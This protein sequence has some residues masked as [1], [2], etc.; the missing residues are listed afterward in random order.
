[1]QEYD[2]VIV[3]GGPA[4][5]TAGLY[6]SRAKLKAVL[7]EKKRLE[8]ASQHGM[9][10]GLPRLRTNKGCGAGAADGE[11]GAKAGLQIEY[12]G[13]SASSAMASISWSSWRAERKSSPKLLSSPLVAS[14]ENWAFQARMSSWDEASYCAICD[15]A[16]YQDQEIAVVGG[17]D[18]AI[19]EALPHPVRQQGPYHPQEVGFPRTIGPDG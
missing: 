7:I 8:P 5:L 9:D 1:M 3:G 15:G 14:P 18:S 4:G 19:E 13:S 6:A 11:P 17:S 2:L 12:D 16:F 10:R